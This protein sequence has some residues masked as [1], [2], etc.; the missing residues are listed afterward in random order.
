LDFGWDTFDAETQMS[1]RALELNQGHATQ[2][3]LPGLVVHDKLGNVDDFFLKLLF[4]KVNLPEYYFRNHCTNLMVQ[5][6]FFAEG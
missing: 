6:P 4:R 5:H 2:M 3:G 1:K